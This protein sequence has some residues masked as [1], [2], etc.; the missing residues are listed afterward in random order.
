MTI[1]TITAEVMTYYN[2]LL[3]TNKWYITENLG[4]DSGTVALY[5]RDHTDHTI[6]VIDTVNFRPM[7]VH[8]LVRLT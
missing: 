1:I 6:E 8:P 4:S 2:H 3:V 5:V 7:D